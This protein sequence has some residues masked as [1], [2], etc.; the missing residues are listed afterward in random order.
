MRYLTFG[1]TLGIVP[2]IS[3]IIFFNSESTISSRH[4][5]RCS[6]LLQTITKFRLRW[7]NAKHLL[8]YQPQTAISP[9]PT[10]ADLFFL[11]G[12]RKQKQPAPFLPCL[13]TPLFF[14]ALRGHPTSWTPTLSH[15]TSV[16]HWDTFIEHWRG[17]MTSAVF[18]TAP[19]T[20]NIFHLW[21]LALRPSQ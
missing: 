7:N 15:M 16:G 13:S 11:S 3:A 5:S 8:L 1:V 19:L 14:P 21:T 18:H 9:P 2:Y 4:P 10:L 20:V 17:K 6:S 12:F